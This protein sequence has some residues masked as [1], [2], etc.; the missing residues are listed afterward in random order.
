MCTLG[1]L[2]KEI[3]NRK[4]YSLV[5]LQE[6]SGVTQGYI[7][8]IENEK[9][10]VIPK[11]DKLDEI[12]K[13]LCPSEEEKNKIIKLYSKLILT[14]EMIEIVKASNDKIIDQL[15][16]PIKMMTIPVYESVA[17]GIGYV[18]GIEPIDYISIPETSGECV[19]I[20][21]LGD[22]MEPTFFQNDLVVL[23]KDIEVSLGE[24]GVFLNK[25]TGE[26]VVKRLKKKNGVYILES[27]NNIF[28][29]IKINTEEIVCCGKVINVIKKDLKKRE[30]P[31]QDILNDIPVD[32]LELAKKLLKTLI[33]QEENK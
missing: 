16:D 14:E 22:S 25:T 13:A 17:A 31:L 30:N 11:K 29:D 28:K 21:V 5:K 1:K 32:K 15:K 4:G 9:K 27:D 26:A 8:D 3:R 18:P 10:G 6:L 2:L 23:K 7:S 12:L 24:I 20:K 19:A 33:P